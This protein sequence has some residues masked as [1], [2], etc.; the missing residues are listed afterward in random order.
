MVFTEDIGIYF[1]TTA[2]FAE[3]ITIRTLPIDAI[4]DIP[5]KDSDLAEDQEPSAL[6]EYAKDL[7]VAQGDAVVIRTKNYLVTNVDPDETEKLV[8]IYLEDA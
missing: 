3:V 8:T 7:A 1:D 6:F 5:S 4:V 2:G